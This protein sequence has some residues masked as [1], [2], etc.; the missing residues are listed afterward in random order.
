MLS[1]ESSRSEWKQHIYDS[2]GSL[3]GVSVDLSQYAKF[4]PY[5]R[6]IIR[7]CFPKN[8]QSRILELGCGIGGFLKVFDEAGYSNIQGVDI[9]REQ[10]ALAKAAGLSQVTNGDIFDTLSVNGDQNL[11]VV[12][13]LD[14]LEHFERGDTVQILAE[15]YR[16]L[17]SGGRL[18][19]HLPNAEGIFGSKI[20]Y[21]D[22]THEMA[23][24]DSSISQLLRYSGFIS[25]NC[26]EDQPIIH[27]FTSLIRR[28][29]WVALTIPFRLLHAAE[30]GTFEIKL[31]QNI[32]VVGQKA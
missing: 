27:G 25:I 7:K 22:Y 14:V 12:L 24:T 13:L 8:K 5:G 28:C 20:R 29:L 3:F 15:A 6:H 16:V 32:L 4:V 2:Y 26:Y 17:R 1:R 10:V 21:A 31:S 11:D 23:Y 19:L 9:S 30:T 18:I